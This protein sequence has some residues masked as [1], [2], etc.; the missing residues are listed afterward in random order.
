[1]AVPFGVN[2]NTDSRRWDRGIDEASPAEK[3]IVARYS[4]YCGFLTKRKNRRTNI[5]G[6]ARTCVTAPTSQANCWKR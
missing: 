3:A 4:E 2:P 5:I 1:M 6:K